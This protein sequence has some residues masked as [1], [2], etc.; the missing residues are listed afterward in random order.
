MET[1]EVL[2]PYSAFN[3]ICENHSTF[4]K[5]RLLLLHFKSITVKV[6]SDLGHL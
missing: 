6:L 1:N 2:E 5:A 3:P 4:R